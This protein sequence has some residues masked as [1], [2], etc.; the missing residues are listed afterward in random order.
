MAPLV[1]QIIAFCLTEAPQVGALIAQLQA[2]G[3]T[4]P[5]TDELA[6]LNL[7]ESDFN[8]AYARCFPGQVPPSA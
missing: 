5:T 4:Q 6:A 2:A 7:S 8:A 3:R 1:M